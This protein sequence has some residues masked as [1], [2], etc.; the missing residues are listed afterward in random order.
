LYGKRCQHCKRIKHETYRRVTHGIHKIQKIFE[1]TCVPKKLRFTIRRAHGTDK[2]ATCVAD[3]P[4][5]DH[6]MCYTCP[7]PQIKGEDNIPASLCS[8][9]FA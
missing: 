5:N 2:E 3:C 6:K 9:Q 7:P 8:I 1:H 4:S